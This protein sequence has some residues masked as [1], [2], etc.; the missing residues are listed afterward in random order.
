MDTEYLWD[1]FTKSGNID[2]YLKYI[3]LKDLQNDN[4]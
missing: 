1:N 2:D 4:N 3:N